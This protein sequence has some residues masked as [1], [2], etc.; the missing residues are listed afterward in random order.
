M[1][2]RKETDYAIRA[3]KALISADGNG[4]LSKEIAAQ[5]EIPNNFILSIMCK[6][7]RMGI[8]GTVRGNANRRSGYVLKTDPRKL[9]L[10]DIVHGFEG[11]VAINA[12]L[13]G[14]DTC[15]KRE[16]CSIYK[17]MLRVNNALIA[18]MKERT[19]LEIIKEQGGC[20]A[21]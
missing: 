10:Y 7:K 14:D 9:T 5:E 11:D 18:S 13:D 17:E 21:C 6:L 3:I 19:I 12:C 15:P 16:T 20:T 4:L 8:A 1:K 2:I